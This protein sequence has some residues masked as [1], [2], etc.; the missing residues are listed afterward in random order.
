MGDVI[1]LSSSSSSPSVDD[2]VVRLVLITPDQDWRKNQTYEWK[3]DNAWMSDKQQKWL[4]WNVESFIASEIYVPP[5]NHSSIFSCEKMEFHFRP[6]RPVQNSHLGGIERAANVILHNVQIGAHFTN[7]TKTTKEDEEDIYYRP[8]LDDTCWMVDGVTVSPNP[9]LCED[10][11]AFFSTSRFEMK[12]TMTIVVGSSLIASLVLFCCFWR[13][14]N[15]RR[16]KLYQRI[17]PTDTEENDLHL[18]EEE[19][20]EEEEGS[21]TYQK[22]TQVGTVD[23]DEEIA[24]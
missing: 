16:A 3:L 11:K 18:A 9:I 14:R 8:C 2:H 4:H 15:R 20:E 10:S 12:N 7:T 23:E 13:C 22:S 19:E 1:T 21:A 6:I 24:E 17:V 5:G